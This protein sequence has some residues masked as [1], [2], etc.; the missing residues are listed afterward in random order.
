MMAGLDQGRPGWM[1]EQDSRQA[2]PCALG[3]P[4]GQKEIAKEIA[5]KS[6]CH[7]TKYLPKTQSHLQGGGPGTAFA[8]LPARNGE[9]RAQGRALLVN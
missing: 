4:K 1:P 2:G 7:T 5:K 8:G 3:R 6:I 9:R